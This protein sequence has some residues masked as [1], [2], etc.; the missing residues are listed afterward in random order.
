MKILP[1]L[2]FVVQVNTLQSSSS[3]FME[4]LD[5]P[6]LLSSPLLFLCCAGDV[7]HFGKIVF[8]KNSDF[9]QFLS[10]LLLFFGLLIGLCKI[11]VFRIGD[12][13]D[14]DC[15]VSLD[16]LKGLLVAELSLSLSF[17]LDVDRQGDIL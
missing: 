15:T 1:V 16:A 3:L 6:T 7:P 5:T 11:F 10:E 8:V 4:L 9:L 2:V 17:V 13:T 14:C 12:F